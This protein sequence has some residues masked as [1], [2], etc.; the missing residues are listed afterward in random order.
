M[1]RSRHCERNRVRRGR[2][3]IDEEHRLRPE[4]PSRIV[5]A[6]S[7]LAAAMLA[8]ACDPGVAERHPMPGA[9]AARGQLAIARTG[10]ASCHVIPGVEWPRGKVGPP[11]EGF[12]A[13]PLI[14]GQYPNEPAV[15]ADY[16]RNAPKYT[17]R[18]GMPAMP[19]TPQEARDVA[20][21]LY[22]LEPR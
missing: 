7:A 3:R 18:A 1:G 10:C 11:L 9:S 19:L 16:V 14:A 20:A 22:T 4:G 15:L 2:F 12:A 17:P 6:S 21:Y 8:A 13:R 5:R